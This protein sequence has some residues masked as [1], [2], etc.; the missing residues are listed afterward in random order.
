VAGRVE[1]EGRSTPKADGAADGGSIGKPADA[2]GAEKPR[3]TD[4]RHLV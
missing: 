4:P 2:P 3:Q 1:R